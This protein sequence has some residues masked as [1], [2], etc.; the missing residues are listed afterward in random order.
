[1]STLVD[2]CHSSKEPEDLMTSGAVLVSMQR[3]NVCFD[4]EKTEQ[5]DSW[6]LFSKKKAKNTFHV[7][8]KTKE[9]QKR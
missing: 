7:L 6:E 4:T 8:N 9:N 2:F 1:M 5:N 3:W